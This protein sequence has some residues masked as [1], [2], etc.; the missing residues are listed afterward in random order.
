MKRL[1]VLSSYVTFPK[2][3][4]DMK[5]GGAFLQNRASVAEAEI[6]PKTIDRTGFSP[7][8]SHVKYFYYQ[9]KGCD[10]RVGEKADV[11]RL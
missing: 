11:I 1:F 6:S 8:Y 7:Y 2:V 3:L 10:V 4:R 5:D 9:R